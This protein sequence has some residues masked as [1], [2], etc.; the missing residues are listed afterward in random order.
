MYVPTFYP[1]IIKVVN[2]K[3]IILNTKQDKLADIEQTTKLL[4]VQL[5]I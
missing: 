3:E 2:L 4:E 1:N 5:P